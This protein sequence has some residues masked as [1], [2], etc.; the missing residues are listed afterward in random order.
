M[1]I[2]PQAAHILQ[3]CKDLH[4][5][6][7]K[8]NIRYSIVGSTAVV[9]AIG[10]FHRLPGDVD[11]I[12]DVKKSGVLK[13]ELQKKGYS[14]E[15]VDTQHDMFPYPLE[16]FQKG[17]SIIEIRG[18]SYTKRGFEYP[19]RIPIPFL[20]SQKRPIAILLFPKTM[21][22]P[23]RY[24]LGD[25]SIIGLKREALFVGLDAFMG[26]IQKEESKVTKR[27]Q[28]LAA[29]AEHL[30]EKTVQ[31]IRSENPGIYYKNIP[32]ITSKTTFFLKLVAQKGK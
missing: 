29:L 3:A 31:Q 23:V 14:Y 11:G 4:E 20:P 1:S 6:C 28:D 17:K 18:G 5:V 30:D 19:I 21:Q 13:E 27:K 25:T 9:A 2:P 16:Y 32:I 8:N 26:L 10:R 12:Y 24:T 22:N 7:S 15:I